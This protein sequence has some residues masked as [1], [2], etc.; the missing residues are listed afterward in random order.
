MQSSYLKG[1]G[2]T[3]VEEYGGCMWWLR[4]SGYISQYAA[5]IDSIGAVGWNGNAANNDTRAVCP[6]L[7]LNLSSSDVWSV[8]ES[9]TL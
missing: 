5:D 4:S 9:V 1:C 3:I 7:H 6:A 8:A 2:Q